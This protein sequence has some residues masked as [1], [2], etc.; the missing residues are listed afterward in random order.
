M[1]FNMPQ[2][3]PTFLRR[4]VL[5][6]LKHLKHFT[7]AV[8]LALVVTL[9]IS[10]PSLAQLSVE[11]GGSGSQQYP[12]AVLGFTGV[13][14]A[15][16]IAAVVR[17]DL[18]KTGL[19]RLLPNLAAQKTDASQMPNMPTLRSAGA[20]AVV[21]GTL[22]KSAKGYE[23]KL[24]IQDAVRNVALDSVSLGMR[25]DTRFAGHQV[26]DRI[27]EK[28]TGKKGFF[29]TRLAYVT[30]LGRESFELRVA[31]WDGQHPQVALRSREPI[32][33]PSFNP[34][35]NKLAYV[36]FE[37]RK[38]SIFVHDL[39]TGVRS[40]V[41]SFR[42]SS[43]APS[44]SPN[45]AMLAAALSRDGLAQIY[46]MTATGANVNRITTSDGIDTEPAYSADGQSLYFVSDRGGQPQIYRMPAGGGQAQRITFNGDYNI[47]PAAS[48]D[49]RLLT[50]I[51][52]RGGRFMTAVLNLSTQQETLVSDGS[53]DE[54]PSFT[55]NSQ[56]VLYASKQRGRGVLVLAS[57]D[58]Q[59]RNTLSL[60]NADIREPTFSGALK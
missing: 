44:F 56:F 41:A 29:T 30:Q 32:I 8:V 18:G 12:I 15:D 45:G 59:I 23:L 54:S 14:A 55:S 20:D 2:T 47:S 3:S 57:V 46:S 26:A 60:S 19:F 53:A 39:A 58:G 49:G 42:G 21:W 7:S 5:K 31:D 33:S 50:Y 34:A 9:T 37:A 25:S 51:T 40:N 52:R 1:T 43:S 4:T 48:P 27:Y 38:A 24:R 17:S 10:T 6:H 28:L 11:I 13:A 16:D 35:G 22:D 36:S